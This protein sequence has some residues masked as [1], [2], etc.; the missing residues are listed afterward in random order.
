MKYLKSLAAAATLAASPLLAQTPGVTD[1]EIKLGGAHDLSGIFAPFSV[2]AVAAAKQYFDEVNAKGG[3]HG[4]KITYIVE[5]HGYQV[6]RAAQAANKL[7]NRDQVFAMLLNLGTPHNLAMFQM[8][9]P[10]G[11]PNVS[12]I[13]AARQMIDPPAPWKFAGTASYYD[14][15]KA[16]IAYMQENEGTKKVCLMILPTDFG[17]EIEA[18]VHELADGGSIELGAEIGHKPDEA[19]FTGA[20]GKVRESGCDTVGM[21]LGI[22]QMINAIATA[23]KLGMDDLKFMLSSA[24]FHT[25]VAKGLAQQGVMDGVYSAAG[26][27]DLEARLGD[28]EVAAWVEAYKAATGEAYPGT[29]ALLGRAGAGIM[30]AALEA[31][32]P[33][34]TRESFIKAM[35]TLD[36]EDKI[37]GNHVDFSAEDHEAADEIFVNKIENGSWKLV[38]TIE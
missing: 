33:D 31:A 37:A 6:P 22:S 21:A 3:V 4:R 28:P 23:R 5:D 26:W 32:G 10:Q 8:M 29:G 34:L 11:I 15:V 24:G 27:Q 2:P 1:T 19:D 35:E 18:A 9:E 25:V 12:P 36:Y 14:A 16:A 20:L 38:Q 30:V 17:K 13:T 7:I